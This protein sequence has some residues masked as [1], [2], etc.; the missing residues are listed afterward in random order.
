[1]TDVADALRSLTAACTQL[2]LFT[3]LYQEPP[4]LRVTSDAR[5][6]LAEVVHCRV[7]AAGRLAFW[8]SWG[9]EIGSADEPDKAADRLRRVVT[10]D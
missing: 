6:D 10:V 8:F 5:S 1:M 3:A 9:E 7:N 4:Y 2:G